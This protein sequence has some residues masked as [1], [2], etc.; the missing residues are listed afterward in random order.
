MYFE[1]VTVYT[2]LNIII[3]HKIVSALF[4]EHTVNIYYINSLVSILTQRRV[5]WRESWNKDIN[6][7]LYIHKYNQRSCIVSQ[8]SEYFV[9]ILTIIPV[10]TAIPLPQ[11]VFGTM[12]PK[13]T[14]RKVIAISHIALSRLACS[15]SWNLLKINVTHRIL[16]FTNNFWMCS[17]LVY[18]TKSQKNWYKN[19][20]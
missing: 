12:S 1:C 4:C 14:E 2:Y 3:V 20:N 18:A 8:H 10:L 19:K 7:H 13:P 16:D 5:D 17:Y 11:Y 9:N 6:Q 15:S